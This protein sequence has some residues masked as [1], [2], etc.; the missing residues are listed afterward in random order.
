MQVSPS[1]PSMPLGPHHINHAQ[2]TCASKSWTTENRLSVSAQARRSATSGVSSRVRQYRL[3][4]PQVPPHGTR[5]AALAMAATA[6]G[7]TVA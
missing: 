5:P 2:P 6:A 7:G 4:L 3:G 1:S